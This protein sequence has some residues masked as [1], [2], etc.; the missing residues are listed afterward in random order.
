MEKNYCFLVQTLIHDMIFL[1]K[2]NE[3]YNF[4]SKQKT[5]TKRQLKQTKR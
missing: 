3:V 1:K 5:K 2:I 4:L